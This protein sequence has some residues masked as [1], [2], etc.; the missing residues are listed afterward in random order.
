MYLNTLFMGLRDT[1]VIEGDVDIGSSTFGRRRSD[2]MAQRTEKELKLT[3]DN[4]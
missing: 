2:D 4:S 1:E 3:K